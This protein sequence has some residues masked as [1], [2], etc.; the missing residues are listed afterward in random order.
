MSMTRLLLLVFALAVL[1][2]PAD[3][4]GADVQVLNRRV[5]Q[6]E[7][8]IAELERRLQT[9]EASPQPPR[10]DATRAASGDWKQLGNWRRLRQGMTMDDVSTLLGQPD[11]VKVVVLTEWTY[12]RFPDGGSVIFDAQSQKVIGWTEPRR[13]DR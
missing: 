4:Q 10:L 11:R 12:G 9:F 1:A 2:S 13:E 5:E 3:A 8:R 6:L 7:R